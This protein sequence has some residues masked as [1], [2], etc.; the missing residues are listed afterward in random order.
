M[1]NN[2]QTSLM[3]AIRR[4]HI[5]SVKLLLN[6]GA[7]VTGGKV[8]NIRP[9]EIDY[10]EDFREKLGANNELTLLAFAQQFQE[11]EIIELLYRNGAT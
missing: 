5:G 11:M 8:V 9:R 3:W 1:D 4:S 6:R 10:S 7:K 2:G